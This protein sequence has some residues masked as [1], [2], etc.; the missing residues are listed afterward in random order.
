[1]KKSENPSFKK[2]KT[3]IVQSLFT[4]HAS[5]FKRLAFIKQQ[6]ISKKTLINLNS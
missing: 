3:K 2:L 4:Y 5:S 6:I 1:M